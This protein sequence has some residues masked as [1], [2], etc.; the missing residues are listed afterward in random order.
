MEL[1]DDQR[2]RSQ[3]LGDCHPG[4]GDH[5]KLDHPADKERRHDQ[6]RDDLEQVV[7][8]GRKEPQVA[9]DPSDPPVV[10]HQA[11][12]RPSNRAVNRPS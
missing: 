3:G 8:A 11:S 12:I 5:P 4:P 7:V 1:V 2:E 9:F 6:G 10:V